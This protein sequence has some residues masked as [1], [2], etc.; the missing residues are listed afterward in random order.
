MV[1]HYFLS[2]LSF[3][4]S[5]LACWLSYLVLITSCRTDHWFW[6]T[7]WT[8]S[9]RWTQDVVFHRCCSR[10]TIMTCQ[11]F[12][13]CIHCPIHWTIISSS[14]Q[15]TIW[16]DGQSCRWWVCSWRTLCRRATSHWTIMTRRTNIIQCRIQCLHT[17]ITYITHMIETFTTVMRS[18]HWTASS[19]EISFGTWCCRTQ[20]S[21]WFTIVSWSTGSTI[22]HMGQS[23]H[24]TV[25]AI[26]TQEFIRITSSRWTITSFRTDNWSRGIVQ[27]V[28]T[29]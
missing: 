29:C 24:F 3:I 21:T 12:P 2:R 7:F 10:R 5:Y 11:T 9:T 26:W 1:K 22:R 28:T 20:Q 23:C 19:T 27:T 8:M 17:R 16:F 18:C 6:T 4:R 25:G 13:G 15:W 14:T